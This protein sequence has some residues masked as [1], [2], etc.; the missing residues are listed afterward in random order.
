MWSPDGTQI[1]YGAARDG[2]PNVWLTKLDRASPAE[3]LTQSNLVE[4][5]LDWTRD[6]K[7]AVSVRQDPKT[8]NDLWVLPM[9]ADRTPY[10]IIQTPFSEI[11]PR[12]SHDGRWL[13]YASNESGRYE[14]Y[15]TPF[16]TSGERWKVSTN[17]GERPTWRRDGRELFYRKGTS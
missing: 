14:V 12:V 16:P 4:F 10:P 17:G 1:L 15:V 2:P 5:P 9:S 7:F 3:R 13:A 8:D 6:G 11:D